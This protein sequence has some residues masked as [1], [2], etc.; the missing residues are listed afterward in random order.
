MPHSRRILEE[1]HRLYRQ[2]LEVADCGHVEALCRLAERFRNQVEI[3]FDPNVELARRILVTRIAFRQSRPIENI[4]SFLHLNR[5]DS[6]LF[7][8]EAHFVQGLHHFHLSEYSRGAICFSLAA[9]KY[10][11]E[12]MFERY[13]LSLYNQ[14]I[15]DLN[16]KEMD[17]G[18]DEDR[19]SFLERLA[20]HYENKETRGLIIRHKAWVLERQGRIMGAQKCLEEAL[21]LL[22]SYNTISDFQLGNFQLCDIF[23]KLNEKE[24]AR[25]LF[26]SVTGPFDTRVLF[27]K[28]YLQAKLNDQ[29]LPAPEQF[30]VVSPVWLEKYKISIAAKPVISSRAPDEWDV[31]R[32][33]Y[34]VAGKKKI[35][36]KQYSLE[37]RLLFLLL[38]RRRL[39]EEIISLLW[40][41]QCD[42]SHV[43]DRL[44]K[45]LA[46]IE[47]KL[48]KIVLFDGKSYF[49]SRAIQI[50]SS[51]P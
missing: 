11:N 41:D 13:I 51:N 46:R 40:P 10:L 4:E 9:E 32:G 12:S 5:A 45:I 34:L 2:T 25:E 48:E 42:P 18:A 23:L 29:P 8:A 24:K 26:E 43:N 16:S 27:P 31:E 22:K 17:L 39:R 38:D 21:T 50:S 19:I 44:R 33:I 35:Q 15:G 1:T 37:G 49:L 20:S 14:F 28:A 3:E 36:V 47:S 30:P 6:N 7:L